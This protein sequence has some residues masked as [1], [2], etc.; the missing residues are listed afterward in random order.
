ML[1]RLRVPNESASEATLRQRME[2]VRSEID[3]ADDELVRLLGRRMELVREIGT[4]KH[5]HNISAYQPQR[6]QQIMRTRVRAGRKQQLS[7]AFV[8]AV[9]EQIHEEA[10]RQQEGL[11][12]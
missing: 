6:W 2:L 8:K 4:L 7:D 10:L 12:G 3:S 5:V 9:F 1:S 11:P